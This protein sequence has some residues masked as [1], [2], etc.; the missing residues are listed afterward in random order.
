MNNK[1]SWHECVLDTNLLC[2]GDHDAE[3]R[4]DFMAASNTGDHKNVG[5]KTLRINELVDGGVNTFKAG[6][7]D[8]IVE[9]FELKPV[10][11]FLEYIFGGC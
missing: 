7:S 10:V 2:N 5:S 6:Y 9:R 11:N 1:Q 4:I 3:F 8:I